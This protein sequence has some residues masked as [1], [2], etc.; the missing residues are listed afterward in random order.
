[1]GPQRGK[2]IQIKLASENPKLMTKVGNA[3]RIHME[4]MPGLVDIDDSNSAPGIQ[5]M[6]EVDRAEAARYGTDI[7]TIGSVIQLVTNGIK[8]GEV[9]F[10]DAIDEMDIRVR[11]PKEFRGITELDKLMV[12]TAKGNIPISNFVKR[13]AKDNISELRRVDSQRVMEIRSNVAEGEFASEKVEEIKAWIETQNFDPQVEV[14]FGG[15]DQ[16]QRESQAFLAQA[17]MAALFIMAI[18]LIT[19]FNSFY[20][21]FLILTAVIMST[22]GVVLGLMI[23]GN[24]FI[25]VMT[26][27]GVIALAGIVVNNNIVLIDTYAHLVKLG[28]EPIEAIIRTGAQRLRPVM[29]T[30][31]TTIIG[32]MPMALQFNVDFFARNVEIGAPSSIMW[33]PLAQA[34]VFGLAVAT[35][36]TLIL[37]PAFLALPVHARAWWEKRKS[38]QGQSEPNAAE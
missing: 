4:N 21:A 26:G 6:L 7:V 31:F 34:I 14:I 18:I 35:L 16:D 32:L 20:H 2:K 23:T 1:M 37:T 13:V 8:M 33:V 11:Y 38:N 36:L 19:Q 27:V 24:P 29:L 3:L 5:W 15:S 10:D 28:T 30:T 12:P 17:F 22:V 9:R 25:V